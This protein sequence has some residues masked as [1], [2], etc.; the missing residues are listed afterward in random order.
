MAEGSGI[1]QLHDRTQWCK[2]RERVLTCGAHMS[3]TIKRM[4]CGLKAQT[5]EGNIL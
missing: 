3:V 4:R 5:H 1:W 2:R